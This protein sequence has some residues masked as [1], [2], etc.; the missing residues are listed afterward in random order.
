MHYIIKLHI[1]QIQHKLNI[2]SIENL[3]FTFNTISI[4]NILINLNFPELV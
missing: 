3:K 1:Y 2:A 4:I